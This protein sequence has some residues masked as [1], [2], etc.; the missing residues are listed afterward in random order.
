M[1]KKVNKQ[2]GEKTREVF[3]LIESNPDWEKYVTDNT[4]EIVK[5]VKKSQ[6][7]QETMQEFDMK[8]T[9]VRSHILRASDRIKN[10]RTDFRHEGRSKLA[11]EL[12]NLMDNVNN[13][14]Q[15]VTTYEAELAKKFKE[16][17]NFYEMGRKLNISPGNIAGTLYGTT[18]KVGVIG[19]IKERRLQSDRRDFTV[20]RE[21]QSLDDLN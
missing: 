2:F 9:T 3:K 6:S 10:K 18:Q 15:Y 12:F 4:A 11:R 13:W 17:K 14:E 19:K 7:M 5:Y 20:L 1:E 16:E 21:N 8:Y